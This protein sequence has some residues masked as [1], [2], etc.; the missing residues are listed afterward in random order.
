M[1]DVDA[2][3]AEAAGVEA[4]T[5][6]RE[7]S[8]QSPRPVSRSLILS[9][10]S[11]LVPTMLQ[12]PGL[13]AACRISE[14]AA[15]DSLDTKNGS[16][17]SKGDLTMMIVAIA[18]VARAKERGEEEETEGMDGVQTDGEI[19]SS[20]SAQTSDKTT[21][22]TETTIITSRGANAEATAG[23]TTSTRCRCLLMT[24]EAMLWKIVGPART[25]WPS[26]RTEILGS[27]ATAPTT[28]LSGSNSPARAGD[29]IIISNTTKKITFRQALTL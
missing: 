19:N 28:T 7:N 3:A 11:F 16:T 2:E 21:E 6:T 10:K 25:T 12:Q 9:R 29:S 27:G 13:M 14:V 17:N 26:L 18:T 22:E 5:E 1:E 23:R 24:G 20:S 4:M 8:K 15:A